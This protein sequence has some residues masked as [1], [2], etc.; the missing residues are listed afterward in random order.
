MAVLR[1]DLRGFGPPIYR[2]FEG[3]QKSEFFAKNHK[4]VRFFDM[5]KHVVF[6]H[7]YYANGH[8]WQMA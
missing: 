8:R 6:Y 1:L 5:E 2:V 4:K 7:K 3:P